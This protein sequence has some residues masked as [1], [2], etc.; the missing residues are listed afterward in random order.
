[1]LLSILIPVL[2]KLTP[3]TQ[4][5]GAWSAGKQNT[6]VCIS[7]LFHKHKKKILLFQIMCTFWHQI[8]AD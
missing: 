6:L 8:K 5:N 3:E 1:M 2:L 7:G 4:F